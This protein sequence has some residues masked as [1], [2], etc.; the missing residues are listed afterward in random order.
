M[1]NEHDEL[2]KS[3]EDVAGR[4]GPGW[5]QALHDV[6]KAH[7]IRPHDAEMRLFVEKVRAVPA[8]PPTGDQLDFGGTTMELDGLTV[9]QVF[10]SSGDPDHKVWIED[11]VVVNQSGFLDMRPAPGKDC[12]LKYSGAYG[13]GPDAALV[14]LTT[15]GKKVWRSTQ[16][17]SYIPASSIPTAP[18][19]TVTEFVL[20]QD[21]GVERGH[22]L[23]EVYS[24]KG[25]T[26]VDDHWV[27]RTNYAPPA[28]GAPVTIAYV[29][30]TANLAARLADFKTE[31]ISGAGEP[32]KT[33]IFMSARLREYLPL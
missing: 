2:L 17:G 5:Q 11:W 32:P 3:L 7:T 15:Q 22:L 26:W 20:K 19:I 24:Q 30:S 23:R 4:I 21:D 27:L 12:K 28:T 29:K 9:A 1:P 16:V 10:V 14:G 8:L 18:S 33:Y 25:E 6:L 13:M 31:A